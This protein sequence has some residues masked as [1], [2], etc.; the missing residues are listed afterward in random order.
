MKVFKVINTSNY[1]IVVSIYC[2]FALKTG[3]HYTFSMKSCASVVMCI[4]YNQ[5]Y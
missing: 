5:N 4:I 3:N 1:L 2:R